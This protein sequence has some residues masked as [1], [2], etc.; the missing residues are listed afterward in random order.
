MWVVFFLT[1]SL[2]PDR[3]RIK[4]ISVIAIIVLYSIY[5]SQFSSPRENRTT[6]PTMRSSLC[7]MQIFSKYSSYAA[8]LGMC[9]YCP[10]VISQWVILNQ[11]PSC[12][13]LSPHSV[14]HRIYQNLSNLVMYCKALLD[15]PLT[16]TGTIA[17]PN[18][19][20]DVV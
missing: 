19:E 12:S 10:P 11:Y 9:K 14:R 6:N 16:S 17:P 1:D 8:T 18:S 13:N 7:T 15:L 20:S 2:R 5:T 4:G 3:L